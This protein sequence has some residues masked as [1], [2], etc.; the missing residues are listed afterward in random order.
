MIDGLFA[1]AAIVV[2]IYAVILSPWLAAH[3][4]VTRGEMRAAAEREDLRRI[5][6]AAERSARVPLNRT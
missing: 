1:A 6:L 2:L 5:H 4:Q 3:N